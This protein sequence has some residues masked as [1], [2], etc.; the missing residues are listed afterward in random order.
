MTTWTGARK[1]CVRKVLEKVQIMNKQPLVILF[2]ITITLLFF[3][4][5]S[6]V[7]GDP[8]TAAAT[9]PEDFDIP[10][11]AKEMLEKE[12][13]TVEDLKT[14]R[15]L[16]SKWLKKF[17]TMQARK[18]D[19]PSAKRSY[20]ASVGA[21]FLNPVPAKDFYKVLVDN[22]LFRPLGYR[23]RKPGSPFELIATVVDRETD[24]SKAL[25]RSNSDQKIYYV[26]VGEE[27]ASAK[28]EMIESLK[29]KLLH[30]GKSKEFRA[31]KEGFLSGG[32]DD[33]DKPDSAKGEKPPP[34]SE[35]RDF[36]REDM[37]RKL[38]DVSPE[39]RRKLIREMMRK[40]RKGASKG[41]SGGG[42]GGESAPR[43]A[44]RKEKGK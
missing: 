38:R 17:Q 29:V 42:S 3:V 9:Q 7:N 4:E 2:Y 10:P 23:K 21:G 26:G 8:G 6:P 5:I 13:L 11:F 27:F 43:S 19:K 30:D 25:I 15:E 40:R 35:R 36:N 32:G 34:K 24:K 31:S 1:F 44:D 16:R 20:A 39:E 28:V 14:D 12:G 18:E 37:R 33:R 22:N 41:G